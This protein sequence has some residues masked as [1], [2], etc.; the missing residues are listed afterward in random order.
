MPVQACTH[1]V[2][3]ERALTGIFLT[4]PHPAVHEGL[5]SHEE[6]Q[7]GSTFDELAGDF[8]QLMRLRS[9]RRWLGEHAGEW[10]WRIDGGGGLSFIHCRNH[11][12]GRWL[13]GLE[14]FS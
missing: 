11:R 14:R 5:A 1:P 6:R 7:L 2:A 9:T 8:G 3:A 13:L 4:R 10:R 12:D